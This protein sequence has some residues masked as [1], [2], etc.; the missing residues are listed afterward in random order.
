MQWQNA[1]ASFRS[2]AM[3][4]PMNDRELVNM[5]CFR[6][7]EAAQRLTHLAASTSDPGLREQL[8]AAARALLDEERILGRNCLA[9]VEAASTTERRSQRANT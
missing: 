2:A 7:R 4:E 3:S 5:A 6:L 8:H 1:A 9:E